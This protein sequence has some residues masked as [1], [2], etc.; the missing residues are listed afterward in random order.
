MFPLWILFYFA[1]HTYT[2]PTRNISALVQTG[3]RYIT[4]YSRPW[5]MQYDLRFPW[6]QTELTWL[7]PHGCACGVFMHL[8]YAHLFSYHY[9]TMCVWWRLLT[10]EGWISCS[11]PP[12][13]WTVEFSLAPSAQCCCQCSSG[14]SSSEVVVVKLMTQMLII[15]QDNN[16]PFSV[17]LK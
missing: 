13:V 10:R 15:K 3:I 12:G 9:I 1:E 7:W 11:V 6:S 14:Q 8:E 4:I 17:N 16:N 2:V 5:F